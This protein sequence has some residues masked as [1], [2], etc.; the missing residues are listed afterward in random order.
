MPFR[1]TFLDEHMN[2]LY[3]ADQQ[4]GIVVNIAT[5]LAI[6]VACL[7]LFG[8]A[9]YNIET[10]IKEIGIRKVL[11]ASVTGITMTL[12]GK[13]L[14]LV[15]IAAIISFP[16]TWLATNM[17]LEDFAYRV[18]IQWW[19][20]A[21]AGFSALVIAFITVSFQSVSAALASPVKSLRTE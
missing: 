3:E 14:L 17:W 5:F 19:V 7:G 20:F 11:G 9:L 15:F 16:V 18:S 12:S 21:A 13:F 10:R 1:Y 6:I 8:M 2:S 4:A